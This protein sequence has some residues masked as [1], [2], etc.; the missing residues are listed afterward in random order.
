MMAESVARERYEIQVREKAQ[1]KVLESHDIV[2]LLMPADIML[3]TYVVG[4]LL[5]PSVI[6]FCPFNTIFASFLMLVDFVLS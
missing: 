2:I 4:G 3:P 1:S 6:V 5:L